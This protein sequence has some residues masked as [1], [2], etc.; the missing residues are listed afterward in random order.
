MLYAGI[1]PQRVR[2]LVALEGLGLTRTT[3]D[4]APAHYRQWLNQLKDGVEFS[5]YDDFGQLEQVLQ[6][7]NP[8]TPAA[9]IKF[10]ARAWAAPR[11]DGRIEL[12]ADPRHKR[13]NA[14]LYQRDQAEACWKC[15][16]AALLFVVGDQSDFA[17][18][19]NVEITPEKLHSLISD[20]RMATVKGAGHMMHHEQPA[21][22]A[23]LIEDFLR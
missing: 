10:I 4:L 13:S 22:V 20:L 18:R 19:M 12:R 5:I 21:A 16:S 23:E 3:A 14:M 1:R 9:H 8:R 17:R 15:I 11:A 6:R 2:R 7:R